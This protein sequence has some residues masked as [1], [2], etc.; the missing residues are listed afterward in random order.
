MALLAAIARSDGTPELSLASN[1]ALKR[2][3]RK[4]RGPSGFLMNG[5]IKPVEISRL[6]TVLQASQC[7]LLLQDDHLKLIID[8]GCSNIVSPSLSDFI[9]GS[10]KNLPIPLA[11]EG[12]SGQLLAKQKLTIR[13]KVINDQGGI[14][15]L[16]CEVY[17]LPDLK[18]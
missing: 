10:L 4:H 11:M 12:I 9:P 6:K 2:E 13:Y 18:I 15:V 1:Q 17:Y 16:Q 7:N 3:L 5:A 8:S 14:Y